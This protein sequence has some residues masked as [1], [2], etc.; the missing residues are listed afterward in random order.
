MTC[1]RTQIM[2]QTFFWPLLTDKTKQKP[3]TTKLSPVCLCQ[4]FLVSHRSSRKTAITCTQEH[5]MDRRGRSSSG[6]RRCT[7]PVRTFPSDVS[8]C[9]SVTKAVESRARLTLHS[10]SK[11]HLEGTVFSPRSLRHTTLGFY[12]FVR[13]FLGIHG[14]A[15]VREVGIEK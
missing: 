11:S 7:Q 4:K 13:T 9:H 10:C 8:R 1:H 3:T 15:W 14:L 5:G 6:H 12:D 2:L